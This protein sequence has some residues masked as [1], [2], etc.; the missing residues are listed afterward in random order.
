MSDVMKIHF[1][2]LFIFL[3]EILYV[4]YVFPAFFYF[5]GGFLLSLW[6][7]TFPVVFYS[8]GA[9]AC[10]GSHPP[11]PPGRVMKP[12]IRL[13]PWILTASKATWITGAAVKTDLRQKKYCKRRRPKELV[14]ASFASMLLANLLSLERCAVSYL[15]DNKS[16]ASSGASS[17]CLPS[18]RQI[19]E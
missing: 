13:R 18:Y 7:F 6:F 5:P 15:L 4:I 16:P 10:G 3:A 8:H 14:V 11:V 9:S 1:P 12:I 19:K 2:D 17:C